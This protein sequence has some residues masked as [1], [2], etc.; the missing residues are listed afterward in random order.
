M[1]IANSKADSKSMLN[2]AVL[3]KWKCVFFCIPKAANTSIKAALLKAMGYKV[4][5]D[6][7][8]RHPA[9][10]VSRTKYIAE[11]CRDYSKF[12]IVRNTWDRLVSCYE[13]K[14]CTERVDT[15]GFKTYGFYRDM[16]FADFIDKACRNPYANVHFF[17]QL[18]AIS[19]HGLVLPDF[20]GFFHNLS[21]DWAEIQRRCELSLDDLPHYNESDHVGYRKYYTREIFNKVYQAYRPEI[22][23]FEFKF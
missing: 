5:P 8:H 10:N 18:D 3:D 15:Q 11:H 7:D 22:D 1:T 12:A 13:Q 6:I 9:L 23:Y 17:P 2:N 4:S 21:D 16:P 14:I 19:Y 20:I